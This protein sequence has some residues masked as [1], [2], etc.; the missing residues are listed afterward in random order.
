MKKHEDPI[1]RSAKISCA[2]KLH[3]AQKRLSFY[4]ENTSVGFIEWDDQLH[5]KSWSKRAEVIFGWTEEEFIERH[6]NGYS[7]VFEED[8]PM[9]RLVARKLISG[10]EESNHLQQRNRTKTGKLIWCEWFNS[11][12]KDKDGKITGIISQVQDITTQKKAAEKIVTASHLYALISQVNQTINRS[13]NEKTLLKKTCRIACEFGKMK[14]AWI[15]SIDE[16]NKQILLLHQ[17]GLSPENRVLLQLVP[18]ESGGLFARMVGTGE[19]FT[20]NDLKNDPLF[21][22]WRVFVRYYGWASCM[23]LPIKKSGKVVASFNLVSAQAD[24]FSPEVVALLKEATGDISAALAVF[25]E[26]INRKQSTIQ[27]AYSAARLKQAQ[28][29][30]HV[31]SWELNFSTGILVWSA[32]ACRIYGLPLKDHIQSYASWIAYVH[33]DDLEHVLKVTAAAEET[34]SSVG[35]YHRIVRRDGT[36]RDIYSH[37]EFEFDREGKPIGLYGIAQDITAIKEGE[38][39]L[40]QSEA[41]LRQMMDLLP[42]SIFARNIQGNYLFVNKSFAELNGFSPKELIGQPMSKTISASADA[43]YFLK[44]DRAVILTGK[45][46]AVPEYSFT[47]QQQNLRTFHIGKAPFTIAGSGEK[48]VLGIMM[49]ITEQKKLD[50]ERSKMIA[51]IMQRNTGL[52]QFAFIISHNLRSPVANIRGMV[53]LLQTSNLEP[54]DVKELLGNLSVSAKKL[55]EVIIDLNAILELNH[56]EKNNKEWVRFSALVADI[57]I[58]LAGQ[59]KENKVQIISNFQAE[60]GMHT[61]K[62][63]LYSI[64]FNLISNSIKYAQPGIRPVIHITIEK[65]NGR[66]QISFK[67]N[68]M[69]IDLA[70]HG[71]HVFG[72]YKRF[73][74]HVTGKGMGL[75]LVKTEVELL[76]GKISMTSEIN[77]GTEFRVEFDGD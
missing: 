64:F 18:Y 53:E 24:F 50:L 38:K 61:L 42:Q 1:V 4:T 54:A 41:N 26:D 68:G 11:V 74:S 65:L 51:E 56:Q 76:G 29:I 8:L 59:I 66:L 57:S 71:N 67:D 10:V 21:E 2:G 34:F 55:D 69:G 52:E 12:L 48:A 19:H 45:M 40:A 75:F 32:E 46:D 22:K 28:A 23:V 25:E 20:S 77:H 60:D 73:H 37:A 47:D 16:A 31:G 36:V 44:K 43:D 9:V 70:K 17:C 62:S 39:A 33:P 63:H 30:A 27:A 49:D 72:L 13:K 3:L 15:G 7:Q 6:K 35:F 14:A 5:V 58:S